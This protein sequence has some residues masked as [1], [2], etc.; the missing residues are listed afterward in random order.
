MLGL[1][2][3]TFLTHS[4]GVKSLRVAFILKD[5]LTNVLEIFVVVVLIKGIFFE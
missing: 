3:L 4:M 2:S 1:A 5:S